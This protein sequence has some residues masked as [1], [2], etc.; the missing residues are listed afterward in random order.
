MY[1]DN[2]N[3]FMRLALKQ[4]EIAKGLN[5]IPVGCV[6]VKDND[7]IA[8]GYNTR[9]TCKT[10]LGHAEI[11]AIEIACKK[12]KSWRLSDCTLYVTLEPCPMCMGAIINA[13]IDK[14]VF[15]AYDSK[16]GCCGSVI[17]LY[18]FGFNH[19]PKIQAGVLADECSSILSDFFKSIRD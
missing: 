14:V 8:R 11:M 16:T 2:Q 1:N 3:E 5:E 18:E 4:A 17:Q 15:G 10:A 12:L 13:R 7:V 6:I 19:K 9:E